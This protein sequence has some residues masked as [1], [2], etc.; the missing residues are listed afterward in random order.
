VISDG[1]DAFVALGQR[2]GATHLL[3]WFH[4]TMRFERLHQILRG[5]HGSRPVEAVAW[6]D[7]ATR[8]KWRLWHGQH[9]RVIEALEDIEDD[10]GPTERP[11]WQHAGDSPL[12]L[13]LHA[14][15]ALQAF[16]AANDASLPNCA[17]RYRRGERVS[18]AVVESM[19]NR[20]IERRMTKKQPMRWSRRGAHLLIQ[21]RLAVLEGG[22]QDVFRRW[23]P[24]FQMPAARE[25]TPT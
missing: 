17:A 19:V 16:L 20:V 5:L 22:L 21:V 14:L 23:Y 3:D 25:A 8:A 2:L 11:Y 15:W 6:Q 7:L 10:L 12:T 1:A 18:A 13:L 9:F 4:V 24:R